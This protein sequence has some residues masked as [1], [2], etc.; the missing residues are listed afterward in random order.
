MFDEQGRTKVHPIEAATF[1]LVLAVEI[2]A[3]RTGN[4]GE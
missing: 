1:P 3:E 2:H 4:E